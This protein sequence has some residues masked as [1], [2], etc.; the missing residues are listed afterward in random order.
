MEQCLPLLPLPNTLSFGAKSR[1]SEVFISTAQSPSKAASIISGMQ[2]YS[3]LRN[4][5]DMAGKRILFSISKRRALSCHVS[6]LY[7]TTRA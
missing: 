4:I 7:A 3:P 2:T 1:K 6:P 5:C